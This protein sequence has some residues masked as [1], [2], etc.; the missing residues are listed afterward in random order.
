MSPRRLSAPLF[1]VLLTAHAVSASAQVGNIDPDTIR[2]GRF[3][4][5][6]MW[7]FDFPPVDYLKETY[8][9]EP[10]AAW[11]EN[12]RLS[13]LRI[14]GCSASFVSPIVVSSASHRSRSTA[15]HPPTPARG[16]RR[17]R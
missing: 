15:A 11:F 7:T 16:A 4:G 13:A 10:D 5:G 14:P 17:P 8:N 9:F 3:D 12:A 2:A 6:K 1:L